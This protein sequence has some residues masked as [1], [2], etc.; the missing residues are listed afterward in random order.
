MTSNQAVKV[1]PC[2][3][4]NTLRYNLRQGAYIFTRLSVNKISRKVMA[5]LTYILL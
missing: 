1:T 4:I 5:R 3:V 2:G